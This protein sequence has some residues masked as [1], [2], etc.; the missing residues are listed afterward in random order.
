MKPLIEKR[1]IGEIN[2]KRL[3]WAF[4]SL[5]TQQTNLLDEEMMVPASRNGVTGKQTY[6]DQTNISIKK[7]KKQ[8]SWM[9]QL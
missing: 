6:M 1:N 9:R 7:T 2:L 4:Q 3:N 8:T 5:W